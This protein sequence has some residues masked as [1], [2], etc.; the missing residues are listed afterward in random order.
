MRKIF[1]LTFLF[2]IPFKV[3]A[4]DIHITEVLFNPAGADTGA[5]YIVIK[6]IGADAKEL[7][8]WQLYPDGI[9]YFT[10]PSFSLG[11]G[12]SVKIVL[13]QSGNNSATVL[14]H[15]TP[16]T[17]MGNTSGSIAL[18]SSTQHDASTLVDFMQYG[19]SGETWESSADEA[20]LWVKGGLIS[21][22]VDEGGVVLRRVS[23]THTAAA[24]QSVDS[25]SSL[26][27][28]QEPTQ[29][30][31]GSDSKVSSG[32]MFTPKIR[33]FAGVDRASIAGAEVVFSGR[34]LDTEDQPLESQLVRYMWNFG[35]GSFADG[36]NVA[37]TYVY[38]GT[39]IAT[40]TIAQGEET[41][42][43]ECIVRIG[44]NTIRINE[45]SPGKEG[46]I[47]LAN[48]A[49]SPVDITK[50]YLKDARAVSFFFPQGTRIAAMG[51]A[52]FANDT[53]KIAHDVSRVF[54]ITLH[55]QNGKEADNFF[56]NSMVPVDLSLSRKD[57]TIVL[58][59][60]TPGLPGVTERTQVVTSPAKP[61][62][63]KAVVSTT[64]STSTLATNDAE[65]VVK[66]ASLLGADIYEPPYESKWL[67]AS[68]VAGLCV[69]GAI[70][71]FARVRRLQL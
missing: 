60:K 70:T 67:L 2:L 55:Y 69:G 12:A 22:N 9:G 50:W 57:A 18:F 45:V 23:D 5:E 32:P 15:Q 42:H 54:P 3:Y 8:G 1:F 59:E 63:V 71:L 47:E 61:T 20:G 7:A 43:D 38:P 31:T 33:A 58:G 21:T 68:I 65:E 64:K 10:F 19:R 41:M 48:T 11:A 46:W 35:D 52:V 28:S 27:D 36:K 56:Y 13:R 62:V 49:S 24:W 34:A 26:E 14:Y 66:Q 6:N 51:F 25:A 16:A 39:Y 53:T 30:N 40:L 17:N 44:G 29:E 4:S 37:H